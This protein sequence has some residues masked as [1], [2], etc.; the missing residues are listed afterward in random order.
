MRLLLLLLL[1]PIFATTVTVGGLD[2]ERKNP[3]PDAWRS[4]FLRHPVKVRKLALFKCKQIN[5]S[6][7][8][9]DL[10]DLT[11]HH[12]LCELPGG[13]L[14]GF[15][16]SPTAPLEPWN[17]DRKTAPVI[18]VPVCLAGKE[19]VSS[20]LFSSRPSRVW[21]FT[22]PSISRPSRRKFAGKATG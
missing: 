12:A 17:A 14:A 11:R 18:N 4:T 20:V 7:V 21:Q 15:T 3:H 1:L 6:R 13:F 22:F 2:D 16:A 8:R 5:H 9:H 10:F 19:T